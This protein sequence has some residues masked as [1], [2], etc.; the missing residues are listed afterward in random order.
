[1]F[2]S[3][4][5]EEEIPD[6]W[7]KGQITSIWKGKGDKEVLKNHRGITTS[8]AI[9]SICEALIDN[10]LE[11]VIPF[12]QAQGGGKRG[13]STCDHLFIMRAIIEISKRQKR[14]TF[15]TFYDVS[16]AYGHA[17]VDDM[18]KIV[19]D[20]GLKGKA[21][22]ILKNMSK[23][24]R[25]SIKT[26]H[27]LTREIEMEIG[28]RQGSRL[29]G[30]LF[31]KMMDVL[32][33][34]LL[35]LNEGF[36]MSDIFKIALL[37]WVDDVVT[38]AESEEEQK[39]IL[40]LVNQFALKHKIQWGKEKCKVMRVGYHRPSEASTWKIGDMPIEESDSYK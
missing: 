20:R 37:L 1:M 12:T 4:W 34:E 26:K 15:L 39:R 22:R 11:A 36:S 8:S 13:S 3:V 14:S 40:E 31:S 25:A 32:A 35:E 16:K 2:A 23:N 30:R 17:N 21:W 9:G 33:E 5:N 19:W 10:R 24:L 7:N 28:G 18:L 6:H 27:G 38:F 29:T